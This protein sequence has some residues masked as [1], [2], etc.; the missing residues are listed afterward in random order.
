MNMADDDQWVND[1][2]NDLYYGECTVC[3]NLGAIVAPAGKST[4]AFACR[5][6]KSIKYAGIPKATEQQLFEA[7]C[8]RVEEEQ[9]LRV[10]ANERDIN[11][12]GL[13][14]DFR[15]SFRR[16]FE[17]AGTTKTMFNKVK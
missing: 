2:V 17:S 14:D 12:S 3:G 11:V 13:D 10:W 6:I 16:W 9:R 5:C 15:A 7:S 1:A 8:Q 4:A